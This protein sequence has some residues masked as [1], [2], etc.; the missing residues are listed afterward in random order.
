MSI[1]T[2][3]HTYQS[4][5]KDVPFLGLKWGER[6]LIFSLSVAFILSFQGVKRMNTRVYFI[7]NNV[8][9]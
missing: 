2:F 1:I 3:K 4:E 5:Q 9:K 7:V 8:T 6:D